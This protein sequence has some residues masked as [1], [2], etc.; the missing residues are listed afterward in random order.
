MERGFKNM[1]TVAERICGILQLDSLSVIS[2]LDTNTQPMT[3]SENVFHFNP[4]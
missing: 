4:L 3:Y 1:C 2:N